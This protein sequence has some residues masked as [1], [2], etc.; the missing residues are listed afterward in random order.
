MVPCCGVIAL[1]PGGARS[2]HCVASI[3]STEAYRMPDC[4]VMPSSTASSQAPS[5][6]YVRLCDARCALKS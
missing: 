4:H 6:C 1:W 5:R 3:P 2:C